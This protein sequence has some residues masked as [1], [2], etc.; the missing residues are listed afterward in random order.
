[1]VA[2]VEQVRALTRDGL[3]E[4]GFQFGDWLDPAAPPERP[5][6]ARTDP[7]LIATAYHHH[8]ARLLAQVARILDRDEDGLHFDAIADQARAAFRLEYLSRTGRVVSDS[9]TG[10]AIAIRFGLL[11]AGA[12]RARAGARL[13]DLVRNG[14]YHI[15]TGFVGTPLICSALTDVEAVD[16]AYHLLLQ[17]E[18]PSWLYPVSMGAT[19]IWER[20]D[21]LL[22]DGSINPGQ[23][24]SFNH[25]AFGAIGD[26]MHRVVAGLAPAEPGYRRLHIAP[27][28]GGGLTSAYAAHETPYGRAEVRWSRDDETLHVQVTIPPG[29]AAE[30]HLPDS[31]GT[32]CQVGSGS[33]Q[34]TCRFRAPK[35]DPSP[36]PV[37]EIHDAGPPS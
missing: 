5:A 18:C 19:T 17:H 33:H 12:E 27:K 28:P 8:T 32:T 34:F 23:M 2:W 13:R 15:G 37:P 9:Q 35:D 30:V 36:E 14:G 25:Y 22:P 10:F 3:W 7:S 6:D 4:S 1:M 20:W 11:E 16:A 26:W 29:A 31:E 21:S 24:T